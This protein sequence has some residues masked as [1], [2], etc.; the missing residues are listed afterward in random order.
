[1]QVAENRRSIMDIEI[2][3]QKLDDE[4][5]RVEVLFEKKF[6]KLEHFIRMFLQFHMILWEIKENIQNGLIYIEN[7]KLELSMLSLNHISTDNISPKDF[8]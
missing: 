6:I 2:V 1:M 4:I 3:V 7:L 5:R 8:Y